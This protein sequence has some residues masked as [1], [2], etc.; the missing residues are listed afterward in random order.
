MTTEIDLLIDAGA[1]FAN[2]VATLVDVN[3]DPLNLVGATANAA[4]KRYYT[5][6]NVVSF[7][8]SI[9]V[10]TGAIG[11]G[12]SANT[13]TA[14]WPGRYV[15]DVYVNFANNTTSRISEGTVTVSPAVTISTPYGLSV[16][17]QVSVSNIYSVV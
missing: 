2:T 12:L 9:D 7:D 3:G 15:Y 4:M 16:A 1:T 6:T 11:I 17:N 14:L 5:S 10:N 8:T 13:T